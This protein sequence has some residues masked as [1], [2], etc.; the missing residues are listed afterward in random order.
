VS[1]DE[2]TAFSKPGI[3]FDDYESD[4][5]VLRTKMWRV[6]G[7]GKDHLVLDNV[8][9][10]WQTN[11]ETEII[12]WPLVPLAAFSDPGAHSTTANCHG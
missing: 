11:L 1:A 9:Y 4:W 6:L 5:F 7:Y 2:E 8:Q 3:D 10:I 12:G